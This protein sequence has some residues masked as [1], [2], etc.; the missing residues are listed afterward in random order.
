MEKFNSKWAIHNNQDFCYKQL[1]GG[2]NLG[3]QQA[4]PQANQLPI[5]KH[6]NRQQRALL[7]SGESLKTGLTNYPWPE[8]NCIRKEQFISEGTVKNIREISQH[9][10]ETKK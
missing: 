1:R 3:N 5:Q 10:G 2:F 7:E 9:L 6:G 8:F 4:K